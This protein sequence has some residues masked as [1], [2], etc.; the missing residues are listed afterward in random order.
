MIFASLEKSHSNN[1]EFLQDRR[2]IIELYDDIRPA[3]NAYLC[4]RGLSHD[5]SEDIIQETFLRLVRHM[6]DQG[7]D[8]NLRGWLFR[9]ARNLSTDLHRSERRW[10]RFDEA[11]PYPVMRERIDPAP[12]PEEMILLIERLT[13]FRSAF[14]QLTP[15]QRECLLL[16]AKG[17]RYR[18]IAVVLGVSV[19]RVGELMQR[20]ISLLEINPSRNAT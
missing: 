4:A 19:A 16:R 3:L 17:M 18:E 12:N 10:Y 5:H 8:D 15:K 9:V 14:A 7:T 20:A 13:R 1:E 11:D 6:V 2:R